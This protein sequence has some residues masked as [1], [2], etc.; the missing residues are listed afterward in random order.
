MARKPLTT[1]AGI[2]L[3][4]ALFGSIVSC[5]PVMKLHG[6]APIEE[7]L[8]SIRAGQDTRGS[9]RRKVGRPGG[10]GIF[11]EEGWFYVSSTVEHHTFYQPEVIDRR[12]VAILFDERD[13]V[14]AVNS[15]GLED[16]RIVDLETNTTPTFGREL[17]ILEQAFGNLGVIT[18]DLI[19]N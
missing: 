14:R 3:G 15:Y 2:V 6:Y 12:V 16:G 9:V 10:T 8:A 5:A 1:L 18:E 11:T 4:S 7:E 13:I 19:D 17:S